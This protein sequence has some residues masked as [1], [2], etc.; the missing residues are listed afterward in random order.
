MEL[1]QQK[2]IMSLVRRNEPLTGNELDLVLSIVEFD[3]DE[4]V[5]KLYRAIGDKL[6]AAQPL[7]DYRVF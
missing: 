5:C 7:S 2:E 3:G 4:S 6:K 1:Q